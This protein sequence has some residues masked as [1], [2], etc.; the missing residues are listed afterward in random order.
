MIVFNF[1]SKVME[2]STERKSKIQ[3]ANIKIYVFRTF[4]YGIIK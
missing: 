3:K 1:I 2:Y 4:G